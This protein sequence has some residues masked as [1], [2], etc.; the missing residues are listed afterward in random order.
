MTLQAILTTLLKP[1]VEYFDRRRHRKHEEFVMEMELKKAKA[2]AAAERVNTGQIADI[3][4]ELHSIRNSGWRDEYLTLLTSVA[5]ILVFI[6]HTQPY[7]IEGFMALENTPMW[8]QVVVLMVYSSAFGIRIFDNF[9]RVLNY[10][11]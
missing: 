5:L 1:V 9:K 11:K 8:F 7:V 4:W 10:G 6:P 3:N 2:K